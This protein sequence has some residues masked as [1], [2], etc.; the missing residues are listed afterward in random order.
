MEKLKFKPG[1]IYEFVDSDKTPVFSKLRY[2][3]TVFNPDSKEI[4]LHFEI[5]D[6]NTGN[7]KDI[8]FSQSSINQ[9]IGNIVEASEYQVRYEY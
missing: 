6:D 1:S 2:L 4:T 7:P 9:Q 3:E 5:S 8:Y